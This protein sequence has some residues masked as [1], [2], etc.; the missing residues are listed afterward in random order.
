[1]HRPSQ[2]DYGENNVLAAVSVDV[3]LD[4]DK[5]ICQAHKG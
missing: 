5:C 3:A 2:F 4:A 1:M